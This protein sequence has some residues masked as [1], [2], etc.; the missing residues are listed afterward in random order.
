MSARAVNDVVSFERLGDVAIIRI[1]NPPINAGST[2]VRQGLLAAVSE[3]DAAPE[4]TGTVLMGAGRM[5]MAGS[6]M[7]EFHAPVVEPHLTEIIQ[8]LQDSP[9]PVVAAIAGAALGGGYELALGC[10]ARVA[11]PEA[12]VG[13]PECVLGMMPGAGGTQ[14]LPRL[15]GVERSI[16]LIC[17]GTRVKAAEAARIGMVDAVADG[18]LLQAAL[19]HLREMGGNKRKAIELPLPPVD[20]AVLEQA[21]AAAL[22][23]GRNRPNIRLAIESIENCRKLPPEKALAIE[24]K[25]FLELRGGREAAALRHLFFAERDASKGHGLAGAVPAQTDR[26]AVI[27][28]RIL[29]AFR[30]QCRSML[31]EG[32]APQEIDTALEEFGFA[33]GPFTAGTHMTAS[34][35][36]APREAGRTRRVFTSGEIIQRVLAAMASEAA[37]VIAEKVAAA[38]AEV[39]LVLTTSYGFP[40]HEGGIVFWA[41]NQSEAELQAV[42]RRLAEASGP[43]FRAGPIDALRGA[44]TTE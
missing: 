19:A 30:R 42:F 4:L 10:D 41:Q 12:V 13:L 43:E 40:R 36:P 6:D 14:R 29:A 31:E 3:F 38:P 44:A 26:L 18:D 8:M 9:K 32:A 25:V 37:F 11:T 23:A 7:K 39:D 17:A 16:A 35:E 33:T 27:G 2:A 5:F 34:T 15:I 1:D 21:K 22:K 28:D 24:R 20:E